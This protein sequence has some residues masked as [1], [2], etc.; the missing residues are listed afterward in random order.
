MIGYRR[1]WVLGA[2]ASLSLLGCLTLG[3]CEAEKPQAE[4]EKKE[5]DEQADKKPVLDNKI[6]SAVQAV[7]RAEAERAPQAQEGAPPPDGILGPDGAERELGAGKAAEVVL[8]N[9]GGTPKLDLSPGELKAGEG[10]RGTVQLSY[11]VGRSVMP[12][13]DFGFQGVRAEAEPDQLKTRFQLLKATPAA[14]Q[15][16]QLPP[17]A[18]AEVAKLNTSWVEFSGTRRGLLRGTQFETHGNNPELAPIVEGA[19]SVL[20]LLVLP[21]PEQPVGQGAFWM[22]KTREPLSGADTITYRM[23]KVE[24]VVGDVAE[25]SVST[26]RYLVTPKLALEGLPAHGVSEFK[27]EGSASLSLRQGAQYPH[28]LRSKDMMG[29]LVVPED[30]PGQGSPIQADL[31]AT[32]QLTPAK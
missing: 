13:I 6:E 12:T 8:G 2:A 10:P 7:A 25:L 3:G 21:R 18:A 5:A 19:A 24:S 15:P 29:A 30:Q 31:N 26:R 23:V 4:A 16:G 20:S 22:V 17:N 27:S 11:R 9:A 28:Q 1:C 32:V 14:N